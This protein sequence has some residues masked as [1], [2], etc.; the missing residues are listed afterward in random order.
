MRQVL[1][2]RGFSIVDFQWGLALDAVYIGLALLLF[3]RMFESAR[4]RGLL[5]KLE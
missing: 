4:S 5:I 1:A 3:Y 2:G